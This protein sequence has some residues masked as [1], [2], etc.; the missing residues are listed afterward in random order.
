[1]SVV[2][3]LSTRGH[4]NPIGPWKS[5]SDKHSQSTVYQIYLTAIILGRFPVNEV[6]VHLWSN[7]IAT[8]KPFPYIRS[9]LKTSLNE[10][11]DP[12][13]SPPHTWGEPW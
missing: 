4:P 7:T 6:A 9:L 13:S 5:L 10:F 12:I 2:T 3:G 1:M 8:E 11:K